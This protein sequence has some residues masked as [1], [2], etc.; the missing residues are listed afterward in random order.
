MESIC[1]ILSMNN[2]SFPTEYFNHIDNCSI[3][4]KQI[5]NEQQI[6]E[7]INDTI[8]ITQQL[9]H[10]NVYSTEFW[11]QFLFISFHPNH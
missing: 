1:N 9:N 7:E 4:T 3:W 8:S 6:K 5:K 10:N 11:N 2:L